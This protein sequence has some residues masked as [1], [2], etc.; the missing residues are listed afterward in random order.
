[1]ADHDWVCTVVVV[2]G[3]GVLSDKT[4]DA[5]SCYSGIKKYGGGGG[6]GGLHSTSPAPSLF[7]HPRCSIRVSQKLLSYKLVIDNNS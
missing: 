1:M 3:G 7:C 2:G 4:S 5:H 6:G